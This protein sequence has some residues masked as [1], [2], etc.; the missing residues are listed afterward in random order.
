MDTN[1]VFHHH[2]VDRA[3]REKL[4]GQKGVVYWFTGLSGSGKSTLAGA[5]EEALHQRG[6]HTFLLDGDNIRTGLC[7]DLDFSEASRIENIRR[8]GEVCKLMVDAGMVVLTAFISP[9]QSDRDSVRSKL[10]PGDFVEVYVDTPLE[11][12]EQRDVK[13]LYK[14][15][16]AG[17]IP[18]FTG[19]SSPYEPPINPE[20]TLQTKDKTV[21]ESLADLLKF[22]ES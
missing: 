21:A 6:V 11:I 19:I 20:I 13:G 15:A 12:C 17:V 8:L 10:A 2:A 18:H 14:K 7:S 16:R 22:I 4:L 9:F 3:Q 1:I 5:F